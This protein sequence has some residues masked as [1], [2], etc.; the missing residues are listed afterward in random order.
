MRKSRTLGGL[1]FGAF[2]VLG[3]AVYAAE[4]HP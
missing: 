3:I 4:P 2:A 1:V